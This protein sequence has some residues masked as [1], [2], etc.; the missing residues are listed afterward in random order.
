MTVDLHARPAAAAAET[1]PLLALT[2]I[3]KSFLGVR[4]LTD[5]SFDVRAGEV[6]ALV[7][8]NGAGKS[9]LM[10]ILGGVLQ[11]D[12]GRIVLGGETL[13]LDG[14]LDAKR[15]GIVLIHQELSLVPEMTVA[16][17]I[18]LGSLPRHW[19]N[20]VDRRRLNADAAAILERLNCRFGP[21]DR[22]S[23][24]SIA[25]RQMVEIARALAVTP[26]IV[27]FD[28][29]TA[30]LADQEKTVLFD[31]IRDLQAA[32][33][34]IVYI[35]HRMDEIFTL[36]GRVSVLRDGEMR[37]TLV[38]AD[39]DEQAVTRL[40]IGRNLEHGRRGAASAR[41]AE[42]L[43]VE[44]LTHHGAFEDVTF[45]VH[46]G[47]IVGLSGLI[48]AGRTEIAE[49][50]F[51]L[52][53]VH[54]GTIRIGGVPVT[55][56]SPADAV[57]L[58]VALVPES[59]KE[60]GLVLGMS[61]SANASLSVLASVSR[62]G[63]LDGAAEAALYRRYAEMLS[64]KA[65]GPGAPVTAL[66]G[67]NQQKIVLAKWLATKPKLLILDEPTRGIDVGSKAEIHNIVRDLADEGYAILVISSDMPEVLG[68]SD[69]I[70]ALYSG[71]IV[72]EFAGRG[73]AEEALVQAIMGRVVAVAAG[74]PA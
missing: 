25:K 30:S 64:V 72:G 61:C 53:R 22:V 44:G 45:S 27:I 73:L 7:G 34:G 2:G 57:R 12:A 15:R 40:M 41:A 35:S 55:V 11:A 65:P 8:E 49:T 47:E 43:A 56:H 62:G 59:R 39:T 71:R 10:K 9:T 69:R 67:G 37:G 29:P 1:A 3:S 38:T 16:E 58:G 36:S 52:R 54:A 31:I 28:E 18:F 33:V 66:S 17:N 21:Q 19:P 46:A 42:V 68:L 74:A 26:R 14:P 60:Q 70:L 20:R 23:T 13:D 5:V 63:F 24:L 6:H 4:A 50:I 51:G 32:G 48:G